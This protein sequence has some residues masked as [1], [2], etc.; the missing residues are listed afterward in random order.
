MNHRFFRSAVLCA[1]LLAWGCAP[2]EEA[3]A[4]S[5]EV[6]QGSPD[7]VAPN[8]TRLTNVRQL[9]FEGENA[10]AYWAY[11]GS[12][13]I[14]QRTAVRGEGC[15]QIFIMD[16]ETG[17]YEQVSTG[18]GRTTC[19][20]FYPQGDRILY[21]ST[22]HIDEA[23]PPVPDFSRGY[24]WP[25][26]SSFD[27][28]ASNADGTG[29]TQLTTEVGYDAEATFS[30][31][32]DRIIF[33]STRNGDLDLYS[34]APDGSDVI[35]I[36]DRVGYDGG[37]F[38]SPDGSKIVWR[39][40]YPAT[41][42]ET[43]DYQSLLADELIRPSALEIFV[44]NADGSEQVQVTDNGAANF[45]PHWHPSGEQIIFSSNMDDP[46]GRNFDLY[47]INVDGS[48]LERVT[49]TDGFDGFPVFSPDGSQLAFG[50]NR[51]ES[52]EG[53]TNVFLADWV[54]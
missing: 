34:M 31:T 47:L 48:G 51:N 5:D 40:S 8:E 49:Y 41:D 22:H 30:P 17:D 16:P 15:D 28:F 3:P 20:Y 11:D 39:A 7:L 21:S 27:V 6:V 52:H 18:K 24:V 44:A 26:Y 50:S 1:A 53:N 23:C 9:T 37:A 42:E 43:A 35:Q 33:T 12:K 4:E 32:G 45:G 54:N 14:F 25:V 29:L 46:S 36:T 13:L 2:A 19:A 10:E 38:Y